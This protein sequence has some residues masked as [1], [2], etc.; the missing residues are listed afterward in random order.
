MKKSIIPVF[1]L[2]LLT[3]AC[4]SENDPINGGSEKETKS[5]IV[6][7]TKVTTRASVESDNTGAITSSATLDV[8]FLRAANA[9]SINWTT[10]TAADQATT[11]T[12][13]GRL[14]ATLTPAASGNTIAFDNAQYYHGDP[15]T[16]SFLKGYYPK[17][18]TLTKA[19][20]APEYVSATW[21]IDGT[22]DLMVSDYLEGS[23]TNAGTAIPLEFRHL[24]SKIT[25]KV[26][27][28]NADVANRWGAV[29]AVKIKNQPV[30]I[31]HK[32]DGVPADQYASALAT[33]PGSADISIRKV[34][35]NQITDAL[36]DQLTIQNVA[37]SFGQAMVYPAASYSIEVTTSLGGT[38]APITATI[39]GSGA[40]AGYN[41][42]ITLTFKAGEITAT[43]TV[44]Q[45]EDSSDSGEIDVE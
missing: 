27:A 38:P 35:G 43:T 26:I 31:T 7:G 5:E 2:I 33:T 29:T 9:T 4:S 8:A 19:S 15:L 3:A 21:T 6:V 20:T 18:A 25:I 42:V 41:H 36:A 30:N 32:F 11:G 37:T 12:G 39:D 40:Q 28:E 34:T 13:P 24:L 14:Y 44:K 16:K 10:A 22:K 1:S 45:W 17:D 23:K